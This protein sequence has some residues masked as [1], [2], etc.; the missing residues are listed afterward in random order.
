MNKC[1]SCGKRKRDVQWIIDPFQE[2]V[3]NAVVWRWLCGDCEQK[4]CDDI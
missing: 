3:Y 1:D 2:D 4:L